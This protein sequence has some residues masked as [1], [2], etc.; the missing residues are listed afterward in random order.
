MATDRSARASGWHAPLNPDFE[1]ARR[2]LLS[3]QLGAQGWHPPRVVDSG[4]SHHLSGDKSIFISKLTPTQVVRVGGISGSLSATSAGDARS[5]TIDG[6]PLLL[7]NTLYVPGLETT[8]ISVAR[9]VDDGADCS[10]H[11]VGLRNCLT[12]SLRDAVITTPAEGGLYTL[13]SRSS[14]CVTPALT[15]SA[16]HAPAACLSP[17]LACSCSS[18]ALSQL[19]AFLA[20]TSECSLST[21]DLV[22]KRLGHS[23]W[24]HA[25]RK[26]LAAIYGAKLS[27]PC[28]CEACVFAKMK[29]SFSRD[30]ATRPTTRP[31]ELVMFDMSPKLPVEGHDSAVGF[32]LIV[33][34]H[35]DFWHVE[36][37][38]YKSEV[39]RILAAFKVMAEKH[40]REKMGTLLFPH[41]LD[42]IRSDGEPVNTSRAMREWCAAEGVTA[43][44]SSPY[45]QWQNGKVERAI[46]TAF[47]GSEALR[48]DAHAPAVLW[49]FSLRAFIHTR[50]RVALRGTTS[51][52]EKWNPTTQQPLEKRIGQLRVWGSKCYRFVPPEKRVKL[53]NITRARLVYSL[54]THLSPR[55]GSCWTSLPR[56][57]TLPPTFVSLRTSSPSRISVP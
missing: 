35:T 39:P 4:A 24:P 1:S 54:A 33:D 51:P 34:A 37:F 44:L 48:K 12:I 18:C 30:A 6:V 23:H 17:S 20:L 40:F 45:C 5:I 19:S 14:A 32:V 46:Q 10:F 29:Q 16:L 47:Q 42:T 2:A 27:P 31:L 26:Q 52:W 50:N 36:T 57:S 28:D 13:T 53:D 9:L 56:S 41:T 11:K 55:P 15:S 8:L 21:G 38:T 43:E 22:H 3:A 49:P 25:L 7:R